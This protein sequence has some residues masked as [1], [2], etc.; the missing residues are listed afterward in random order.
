MAGEPSLQPGV[1]F[2]LEPS[3]SWKAKEIPPEVVKDA[4]FSGYLT[5][6]GYRST[7]FETKD[8][9]QYA[10]KSPGVSELAS[11]VAARVSKKNDFTSQI[12]EILNDERG[13]DEYDQAIVDFCDFAFTE[14]DNLNEVVE[15]CADS[16]AR[17]AK[18]LAAHKHP[19]VQ[20]LFASKIQKALLDAGRM[21]KESGD[22][23]VVHI[24]NDLKKLRDD[25]SRSR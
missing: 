9:Q 15:Q 2:H 6:E 1:G 24:V 22:K 18:N 7:V 23:S 12:D 21:I 5:I 17:S 11:R 25:A 13:D 16:F 4:K 14:L 3:G 20:E 10:Q 8:K 19:R